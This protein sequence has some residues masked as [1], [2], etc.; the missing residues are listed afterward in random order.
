MI[1]SANAA[2]SENRWLGVEEALEVGRPGHHRGLWRR[3]HDPWSA[4]RSFV[5][6]EAGKIIVV[7]YLAG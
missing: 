2:D 7:I 6:G 3:N 4:R 5:P 1:Q